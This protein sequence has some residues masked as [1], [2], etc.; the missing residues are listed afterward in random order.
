MK[1]SSSTLAATALLTSVG[2]LGCPGPQKPDDIAPDPGKQVVADGDAW[3]CSGNLVP[4]TGWLQETA[5]VKL[6]EPDAAQKAVDLARSRLVNRLCGGASNCDDLHARVDP[7][8]QGADGAQACAMVTIKASTV[9]AWRQSATS[10]KGLDETLDAAARELVG[11]LVD[12][13]KTPTVA[14]DKVIDSGV[15]GGERAEW[16]AGRM[17]GALNRAGARVVPAPPDWNGQGLPRAI[18]VVVNARAFERTEAQKAVVEVTWVARVASGKTQ[19][20]ISA[21]PVT[22]PVDAAPAMTSAVTLF[23]P[24]DPGLSVRIESGHP[25][26][27]LCIGEETQVWLASDADLNVRVFDLYGSDGALL[28]FPNSDHPDGRVRKGESLSLGVFKAVPAPNTEVERFL[29]VAAP[30]ARDLGRFKDWSGTCRVPTDVASQLH[31]GKG[32]PRGS[33][34]SSDGFRLITDATCTTP[35]SDAERKELIGQLSALPD[36]H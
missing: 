19:S 1:A 33:R 24:N 30:N 31:D 27:G 34:S 12:A 29:V 10:L 36:C 23:P 32:V 7:W 21:K 4:P 6:T 13:K 9:E 26:G 15:P 35:V 8:K 14:I 28:L 3:T 22:F 17:S 2:L 16:L 20:L 5:F 25:G 11:A 18:D